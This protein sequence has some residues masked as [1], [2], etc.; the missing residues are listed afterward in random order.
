MARL[1]SPR[2]INFKQEIPNIFLPRSFKVSALPRHMHSCNIQLP[3]CRNS[4][5]IYNY[6]FR[7]QKVVWF[8]DCST[9]SIGSHPQ[10]TGT[11]A[12]F[13]QWF[14]RHA[15]GIELLKFSRHLNRHLLSDPCSAFF[16]I[17]PCL[18]LAHGIFHLKRTCPQ[19]QR[20]Y[21]A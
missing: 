19:L 17:L 5:S 12:Y 8:M 1:P 20:I 14:M 2:W 10:P 15:M 11:Y 7:I 9:C 3:S 21:D 18:D 16:C 13:Y 6:L 4:I